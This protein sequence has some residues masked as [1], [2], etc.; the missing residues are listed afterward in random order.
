[1][2]TNCQGVDGCIPDC[3]ICS[4]QCPDAG[5]LSEV[6]GLLILDFKANGTFNESAV[7][8]AIEAE[9]RVEGTLQLT[10]NQHSSVQITLKITALQCDHYCIQSVTAEKYA[11]ILNRRLKNGTFVIDKYE[12]LSVRSAPDKKPEETTI[13]TLVIACVISVVALLALLVLVLVKRKVSVR[14]TWVPQSFSDARGE[15]VGEENGKIS[16]LESF[17]K[18]GDADM[19]EPPSKQAKRSESSPWKETGFHNEL[20]GLEPYHFDQAN[21]TEGIEDEQQWTALHLQA[22]NPHSPPNSMLTPP[23]EEQNYKSS[24]DVDAVGPGGLTALHVAAMQG[25]VMQTVGNGERNKSVDG[26]KKKNFV[27][28]LLDL[29]ANAGRFTDTTAETPLHLAARFCHHDAAEWLLVDGNADV[30]ARDRRGRTPLHAAVAAD[31][32]DVVE[33]LLKQPAI[34]IDAQ[35]DDG[36]TPVMVAARLNINAIMGLLMAAKTPCNLGL[37]D[38]QGKTA[39]HWAAAVNNSEGVMMLLKQGAQKDSQNHKGETPLFLAGAEGSLESAKILLDNFAS[40]NIQDGLGNS[41]VDAA[42]NRGHNDVAVLLNDWTLGSNGQ[43]AGPSQ[44]APLP[45]V[46][47]SASSGVQSP[48]SSSAQSPSAQCAV[49]TS[50]AAA[51]PSLTVPQHVVPTN[52]RKPGL[53]SDYPSMKYVNPWAYGEMAPTGTFS[54]FAD[55]GQCHVDGGID[56]TVYPSAVA[57]IAHPH[58]LIHSRL[59]PQGQANEYMST[60]IPS[61]TASNFLPS[62]HYQQVDHHTMMGHHAAQRPGSSV[63]QHAVLLNQTAVDSSRLME[64]QPHKESSNVLVGGA[65]VPVRHKHSPVIHPGAIPM[66]PY[67]SPPYTAGSGRPSPQQHA[68]KQTSETTYLTPSPEAQSSPEGW[69]TESPNG[70]SDC[71]GSWSVSDNQSPPAASTY[72]VNKGF[73]QPAATKPLSHFPH[74]D[75]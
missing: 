44:S 21:S 24:M 19:E 39:L 55:R 49:A 70:H 45:S 43:Q 33:L 22:A 38:D 71:G 75:Y 9:F 14:R 17:V 62:V 11:E 41:P 40:R 32:S 20:A 46:S 60:D 29:G 1:M 23:Q 5:S 26:K 42:I 25:G 54:H 47:P 18:R 30:N 12:V 28:E 37:C 51:T 59:G 50:W 61:H 58:V 6:P 53:S 13:S 15:P 4:D 68:L 63:N 64:R 74:R 57:P 34:D 67:P 16:A 52:F 7:L 36:L 35:D 65:A 31:G 66:H 8:M 10:D 69:S 73:H 48:P 72:R 27:K 2:E 56:R 3:N